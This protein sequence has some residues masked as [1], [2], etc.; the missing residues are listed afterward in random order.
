V[1]LRDCTPKLTDFGLARLLDGDGPALT[2][3]G[4]AAGTPAYMAPEQASGEGACT[5]AVDIWALGATLYEML[6]GK[7]PFKGP[8]AR[9]TLRL[10]LWEA[11]IAPRTVN[12]TVPAEM[13]RICLKCLSK[14][15]EKRYPT[16]RD[17]AQ[18]LHR[19]LSGPP[20]RAR[21]WWP[22]LALA[23]VG[24]AAAAYAVWRLIR[25]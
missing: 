10:V 4:V 3:S 2:E 14:D 22:W 16:A 19:F 5:P 17:L 11:P 1:A 6:T 21:R 15:P 9:E 20:R 12:P 25:G 18:D 7:P 8:S 24:L 23:G 13:E